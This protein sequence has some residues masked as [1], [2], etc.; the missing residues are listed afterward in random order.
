[1]KVEK[2][3]GFEWKRIISYLSLGFFYRVIMI[4]TSDSN[5]HRCE[6]SS[7]PEASKNPSHPIHEGIRESKSSKL[8]SFLSS[9]LSNL[10][11]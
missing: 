9:Q 11:E 1:V 3:Y 6:Y 5:H 4:G 10:G 8:V 2:I 7:L